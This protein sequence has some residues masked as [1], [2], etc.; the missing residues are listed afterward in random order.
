MTTVVAISDVHGDVS[1][2]GVDRFEDIVEVGDRSVQHAIDIGATAHVFVGDLAD[3]HTVRSHRSVAKLAEWRR[4]LHLKG[5]LSIAIAGN[6][7]VI[8]DGSGVT[9]LD[10]L[11]HDGC[12]PVATQPCTFPVGPDCY[13][14]A[15]PFCA[16]SHNYD[17]EAIV[18]KLHENG[19]KIDI[20]FGHLNLRG[21]KVGSETTDFPR[22]RDVFW[23][24]E[25]LRELY[26]DALLVGG[27]Y[28]TPQV[29]DGVH[30][31][32][33]AVCLR[34]GDEAGNHTGFSVFKRG[35]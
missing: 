30:I 31:V 23:P 34:F 13:A 27:H 25:V 35:G 18:R 1:T 3:P 10:V 17:P 14:L 9:V 29:F 21:I 8:E 4:R 19:T 16:S 6:H 24:T 7:D 5:I 28:H 20:V 33:S 26:P 32:G 22:G 12:G 15:L 11:K 2:A